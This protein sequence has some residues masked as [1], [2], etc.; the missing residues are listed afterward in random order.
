MAD[1]SGNNDLHCGYASFLDPND[2]Q[3]DDLFSG[4]SAPPG[5]VDPNQTQSGASSPFSSTLDDIDFTLPIPSVERFGTETEDSKSP[6]PS[7]FTDSDPII[8]VT[9]SEHIRLHEQRAF[10]ASAAPHAQHAK[11]PPSGSTSYVSER[12]FTASPH[13]SSFIEPPVPFP[14][15]APVPS[16]SGV[17]TV[18]PTPQPYS[19]SIGS[20]AMQHERAISL[21]LGDDMHAHFDMSNIPSL[22]PGISHQTPIFSRDGEYIGDAATHLRHR[23][24][25]PGAKR[26]GGS[27]LTS[28]PRGP[29]THQNPIKHGPQPP[30]DYNPELRRH[31]KGYGRWHPYESTSSGR[32]DLDSSRDSTPALHR[33]ANMDEI[34]DFLSAGN[35]TEASSVTSAGAIGSA[36]GSS[37]KAQ[38][39]DGQPKG[40]KSGTH[41]LKVDAMESRYIIRSLARLLE[42]GADSIDRLRSIDGELETTAAVLILFDVEKGMIEKVMANN[43]GCSDTK[44]DINEGEA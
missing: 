5:T 20:P 22:P 30:I 7:T 4:A 33:D 25:R 34:F 10:L 13:A 31:Q 3:F 8:T 40:K 2:I 9:A 18:P 11:R 1:P 23:R 28:A 32:L 12:P 14:R 16:H 15:P 29:S 19:Q 17:M 38:R 37:S 35:P 36:K 44:E 39:D 42:E 24:R 41:V 26:S 21:P 27:T 43:D 6:L